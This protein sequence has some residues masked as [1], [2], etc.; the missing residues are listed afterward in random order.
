MFLNP[1]LLLGALGIGV[2]ILIHLLNQRKFQRVVWAAMRF[3]E[4]SLAKNRQRMRIENLL[5]LLLRCAIVALFAVALARPALSSRAAILGRQPVTA[6]L[7]LDQSGSMGKIGGNE[8]RFEAA[9]RAADQIVAGL[10]TGSSVAL[11]LASDTVQDLIPQPT[12]DLTLVRQNLA[13][14]ELTDRGTD[15]SAALRRAYDILGSVRAANKQLYILTDGQ[16]EG[17]RQAGTAGIGP[18]IREMLDA[19]Q[20]AVQTHVCLFSDHDT[21]NL[22]VAG[23]RLTTELPTIEKPLRFDVEV[24]NLGN[25]EVRDVPVRLFLDEAVAPV[26]EAN[27]AVIPVHGSK[28]VTLA[29]R[30]SA[31]GYHVITAGLPHDDL[32]A[33]DTRSLMMRA[34]GEVHVLLV[35][36]QETGGGGGG[37]GGE[38]QQ[39]DEFFVRNALLAV[40]PELR[41]TYFIKT[42][43]IDAGELENAGFDKYDVVVLA[44]VPELSQSTMATLERSVSQGRGLLVFSGPR[45]N[46]DFYRDVLYRQHGLLPAWLGEPHGDAQG[47]HFETLQAGGFEHFITRAWNSKDLGDAT[48]A[49]FFRMNDLFSDPRPNSA[50]VTDSPPGPTAIVAR[51][52]SGK[53]AIAEHS[54]GQGR[55]LLI[56]TTANTQWSDLPARGSLFVPL[57]HRILDRLLHRQEENLNIRVGQQLKLRRPSSEWGKDVT[58]TPPEAGAIPEMTRIEMLD[59]WPTLA[60]GRT[61]RSGIYRLAIDGAPDGPQRFAVQPNPAESNLEE[62]STQERDTLGTR[63]SITES[64]AGEPVQVRTAGGFELWRPMV[65]LVLLLVLVETVLAF[66][67]SRVK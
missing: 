28:I 10:P 33:D 18:D 21:R 7:V 36:G 2:P 23:L 12:V 65:V 31:S 27:L 56:G 19:N 60:F 47:D 66:R 37:G 42:D 46:L 5:L 6:V 26:D 13:R 58:I 55:V 41:G 62:L 57:M 25:A 29:C 32:R 22:A 53:T 35:N 64:R 40:S 4:L 67:F 11:L 20:D 9:R 30:F 14:A 48:A 51:Y 63:A 54:Y 34:L 16:A 17:W 1:W 50:Q 61:D 52:A 8:C 15:W 44:N 3:V 24:Q 43:T 38:A 49:R 59:N 45:V 39:E